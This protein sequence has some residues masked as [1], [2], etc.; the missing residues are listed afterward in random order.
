[1]CVCVCVCVCVIL[2]VCVHVCVNLYV[3]VHVTV[4]E[5]EGEGERRE[6]EREKFLK[7]FDLSFSALSVSPPPTLSRLTSTLGIRA[8]LV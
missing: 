4:S 2:Y 6:R 7:T 8:H 1:M 5:R 3:C